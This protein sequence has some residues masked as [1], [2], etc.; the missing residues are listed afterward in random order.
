MERQFI[1]VRVIQLL[2]ELL[3]AVVLLLLRVVG[4][5][6]GVRVWNNVYSI[7]TSESTNVS[8]SYLGSNHLLGEQTRPEGKGEASNVSTALHQQKV[9]MLIW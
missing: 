8:Q 3:G 7:V 2:T 6:K 9:I 4:H 5:K 1:R